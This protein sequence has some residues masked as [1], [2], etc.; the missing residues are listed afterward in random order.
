M[1]VLYLRGAGAVTALGLDLERTIASL[2][3]GL[4][5][6]RRVPYRGLTGN[7]L[8]AAPI[9]GFAEAIG[10]ADRYAA[11][12]LP[13]IEACLSMMSPSEH[14]NT[15]VIV[16]LPRAARPG[17][18]A[19]LGDIV[20]ERLA[21]ALRLPA[22]M[23]Q[24]ISLGR[25]SAFGGLA[26][27]RRLVTEGRVEGCIVGGVDVLTNGESLRLL[28]GERLLKED[29]DGFIPGEAAAFVH[30]SARRGQSAWGDGGVVVAG[31]GVA[32][33]SATGTKDDPLV[34]K[35]VLASFRAAMQQ[36]GL[37]E[38]AVNLHI[39][40]LNG[41][42]LA[43]EDNAMGLARYLRVPTHEYDVWHVASYLG[44]T[45]AACGAIELIWAQAALE[46]GFAPGTGVMLSTSDVE[47]RA[48]AVLQHPDRPNRDAQRR[49]VSLGR[50]GAHDRRP[51]AAAAPDHGLVL[52]TDSAHVDLVDRH[53]RELAW[54]WSVRRYHLTSDESAW[55]D[56]DRY[57]Q[58]LLAHLDALAW[59]ASEGASVVRAAWH[60]EDELDLAAAAL[61][62]LAAPLPPQQYQMI[63][64]KAE[65]S[66][67]HERMLAGVMPH[68]PGA[69]FEPLARR[70]LLSQSP[71]VKKAG[72][73][74]MSVAQRG[75]AGS[76]RGALASEDESVVAAAIQ[77]AGTLGDIAQ[78]DAI[79]ARLRRSPRASDAIQGGLTKVA[80]LSLGL[81]GREISALRP[82]RLAE[83]SPIACAFHCL[84]EDESFATAIART[85]STL[86]AV[87]ACGWSGEP[88]L[89]PMLME[90]LSSPNRQYVVAAA[91]A[92]HRISG[93]RPMAPGG[94]AD[95]SGEATSRPPI[96]LEPAP[97]DAALRASSVFDTSAGRL[98]HGKP[99]YRGSAV[100]HLRRPDCAVHERVI[101]AWEHAVI[102]QRGL[103]T[104][105]EQFVRA[106]RATLD[107]LAG[108]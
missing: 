10:G 1:S 94:A 44:E 31:V 23:V 78:A 3:G 89:V 13:A 79:L 21:R 53:F 49:R 106:Q 34:G 59:A 97:W 100:E 107:S 61:I 55:V 51:A 38:T 58:R 73:R 66:P 16:G 35:A 14:Q 48:A 82:A 77:C 12:A 65:A 15:A 20:C 56:I 33:E 87:D 41:T 74:A 102:N 96:A 86:A 83:T 75:D 70:F 47:L 98:R 72:L 108:S 67:L 18:P 105:P 19:R 101:A 80:L 5:A 71:S 40:D 63:V 32:S 93:L 7:D 104:H 22:E 76:I 54:L 39:N 17:V 29:W 25:V 90:L 36:A 52:P 62:L 50:I 27:A 26:T 6:F 9:G 2:R 81:S 24:S 4:D 28:S 91:R 45:G 11:L 69:L 46:L 88:A 85:P 103:P 57:E 8:Q 43:F 42:R 30:V 92:L 60:A 84:R 99:W 95:S 37:A 64:G 68:L